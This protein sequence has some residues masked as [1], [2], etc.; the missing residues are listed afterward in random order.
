MFILE[1][2]CEL[3][4]PKWTE[5]AGEDEAHVVRK[6]GKRNGSSIAS[7]EKPSPIPCSMKR[8]AG[9]PATGE[10]KHGSSARNAMGPPVSGGGS[11]SRIG[12]SM[13]DDDKEGGVKQLDSVKVLVLVR[14]VTVR[15]LALLLRDEGGE[16]NTDEQEDME[17]ADGKEDDVDEGEMGYVARD[18]A[19]AWDAEVDDDDAARLTLLEGENDPSMRGRED[20]PIEIAWGSCLK[21]GE[22]QMRATGVCM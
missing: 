11:G 5:G 17:A 8:D 7:P 10:E 6:G 12:L 4:R 22:G 21:M 2:E 16:E 1:F 3:K 14:V 19:V 13:N 9:C 15:V 20:L 18:F